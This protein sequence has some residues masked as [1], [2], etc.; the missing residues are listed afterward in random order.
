MFGSRVFR[1]V[2]NC[3]ECAEMI[4]KRNSREPQS[5]VVELKIL[6]LDPP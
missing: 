2:N 6:Q 4:G 5:V 3:V 1:A